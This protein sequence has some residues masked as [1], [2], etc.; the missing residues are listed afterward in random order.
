MDLEQ[1]AANPAEGD[2][3]API[4][5][6]EVVNLDAQQAPE[7][8]ANTPAVGSDEDLVKLGLGDPENAPEP[9]IIEVEVDGKKIKVSED[10]KDFLL[11]QADY[12][13]KTTEVARERETVQ[14]E[15]ARIEQIRY[16]QEAVINSQATLRALDM[17]IEQ[18]ANT[19]IGGLPQEQ[20]NAMQAR[21]L[22]LQAER[23]EVNADV[24]AIAQ[25]ENQRLSEEYGKQREEA[26]SEAAKI[27]PNFDDKRR[28]EL[29]TL[30]VDLGIPKEDVEATADPA[31]YRILHLADIGKKFLERQQNAE[32]I[33]SAQAGNPTARLEGMADGGKR[34]EEMTMAEYAAARKAGKI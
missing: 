18:L 24:D 34:P 28:V 26:L 19:P 20:V 16:V 3:A 13:K 1:P 8:E 27:I 23:Q 2:V 10:G 32:K 33:Q 30:A 12:T 11:R 25:I 17:Q 22:Q 4:Q 14:A 7:A 5:E 9:Q 6:P 21:L 29:E 15:K 31:A